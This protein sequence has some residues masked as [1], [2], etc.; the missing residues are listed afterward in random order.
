MIS[1]SMFERFT[2]KSC[3]SL[4]VP[5]IAPH[6][7]KYISDLCIRFKKVFS[8]EHALYAPNLLYLHLPSINY[9]PYK[10]VHKEKLEGGTHPLCEFCQE[11]FFGD[12][13]LFSHM[14]EKHEECFLCKGN[15]IRDK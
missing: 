14:R 13:E 9:R 15:G 7:H 12:D 1:N 2:A 6:S 3:G 8:H 5:S 10:T 11:C 4:P